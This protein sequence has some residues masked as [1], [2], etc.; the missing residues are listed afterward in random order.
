MTCVPVCRGAPIAAM[1]ETGT[2]KPTPGRLRR[3]R[4]LQRLKEGFEDAQEGIDKYTL[5]GGY[6]R[7]FGGLGLPTYLL[8]F[9][10]RGLDK[11]DK[12]LLDDQILHK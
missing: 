3:N 4:I 5:S 11:K 2:V 1:L 10:Y 9:N 8:R 12:E 6:N 7:G